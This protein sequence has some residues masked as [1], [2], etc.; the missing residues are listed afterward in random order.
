MDKNLFKKAPKKKIQN[1]NLDFLHNEEEEITNDKPI[2]TK[3]L[4]LF[5]KRNKKSKI[6]QNNLSFQE[7]SMVKKKNNN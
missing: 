4:T 1:I 2:I 5:Q 7:G 6:I 3:N